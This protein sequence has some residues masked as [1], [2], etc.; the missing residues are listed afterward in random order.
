VVDTVDTQRRSQLGVQE[1]GKRVNGSGRV[2][3]AAFYQ[4]LQP[5]DVDERC[6][7]AVEGDGCRVDAEDEA[8]RQQQSHDRPREERVLDGPKKD[9]SP[10]RPAVSPRL[11]LAWTAIW[12]VFRYVD[13]GAASVADDG[14]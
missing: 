9:G 6:D 14:V 4:R 5:V 8:D 7:H 13:G 12:I 10:R 1:V 2:L 11:P 3:D